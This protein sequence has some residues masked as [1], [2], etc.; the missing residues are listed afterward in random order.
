MREHLAEIVFQRRR[1]NAG[2]VQQ[3]VSDLLRLSA[4]QIFDRQFRRSI[5]ADQDG[6][7]GFNLPPM[8]R[9]SRKE[10][11]D[12]NHNDGQARDQARGQAKD[13]VDTRDRRTICADQ[14]PGFVLL[15][16]GLRLRPY[17][18]VEVHV[19]ILALLARRAVPVLALVPK[20]I[21][22][23]SCAAMTHPITEA[24][25]TDDHHTTPSRSDRMSHRAGIP[26]RRRANRRAIR[27]RHAGWRSGDSLPA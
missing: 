1:E 15:A 16:V 21:G 19:T 4:V 2:R 3:A 26:D 13:A 12:G 14:P 9:P 8:Q 24:Q 27:D 6:V 10:H 22:F 5:G 25:V 23:T 17:P 11:G 20:R 18:L 7:D